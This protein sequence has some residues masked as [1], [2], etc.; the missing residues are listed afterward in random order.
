[1]IP[2]APPNTEYTLQM[3][4]L[5]ESNKKMSGSKLLLCISINET[6]RASLFPKQNYNVLSPNSIFIYLWAIYSIYS[7][8]RSAYFLQPIRQTDPGNI[9]IRQIHEM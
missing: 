5:W 1:M 3:K 6:V 9:E 7:Q 2:L 8:D 4:G